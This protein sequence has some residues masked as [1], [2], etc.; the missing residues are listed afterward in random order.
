[1]ATGLWGDFQGHGGTGDHLILLPRD[2]GFRKSWNLTTVCTTAVDTR[3]LGVYD[4]GT[5]FE[6]Q[7]LLGRGRERTV[8]SWSSREASGVSNNVNV[9]HSRQATRRIWGLQYSQPHLTSGKM[10]EQILLETVSKHT[11]KGEVTGSSEH[12][13]RK[14]KSSLTSLLWWGDGWGRSRGWFL[15]WLQL[16]FYHPHRQADEVQTNGWCFYILIVSLGKYEQVETLGYFDS[17]KN[18]HV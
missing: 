16:D 5:I 1:M 3:Y 7:G 14:G 10:M 11:K 18:V 9:T 6:E 2:K 8:R 4:H 15:S 12:G 17:I 13:F